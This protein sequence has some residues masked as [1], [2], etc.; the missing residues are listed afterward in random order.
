MFGVAAHPEQV[1]MMVRVLDAYCRE[2]GIVARTADQ[3]GV[4]ATIVALFESGIDTED[5]L[6]AALVDEQHRRTIRQA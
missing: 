3:D 4:A 6:M 5:D 2:A 1:A